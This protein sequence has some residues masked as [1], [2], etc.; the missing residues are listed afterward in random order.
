MNGVAG[1]EDAFDANG[2]LICY[3]TPVFNETWARMEKIYES[4]RAKAIGVSNFSVKKY[5]QRHL[6][7]SF[8]DIGQPEETSRDC[9]GCARCKPSRVSADLE[10]SASRG[11]FRLQRVA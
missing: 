10:L 5:A 1:G 2:D 7:L 6:R 8:T 4:G 11:G 9:E 3:E